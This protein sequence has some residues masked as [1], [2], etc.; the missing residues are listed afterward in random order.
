LESGRVVT[1][2]AIWTTYTV[3]KTIHILAAATWL[4]GG[5][6]VATLAARARREQSADRLAA[7]LSLVEP[8][9]KRVFPGSGLILV[10]TGFWMI[11]NGDLP[12]DTWVILGIIA[13][14]YS[15]VAGGA[16]IGPT[17]G[18]AVQAFEEGGPTNP[19]AAPLVTRFLLLAR[20][21]SLV[22]TLAV[23]DMVIKPGT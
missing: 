12:Y 9:A 16:L 20:I 5:S 2:L 23:L 14:A 15:F 3:L 21:D 4:G 11:G 19:A 8:V 10:I 22:L 13:W 1:T 18:R 6:F 7:L 17:V